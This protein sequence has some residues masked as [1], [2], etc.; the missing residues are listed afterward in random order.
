[1]HSFKNEEKVG[2]Q[3][4]RRH[5]AAGPTGLQQFFEESFHPVTDRSASPPLVTEE[6]VGR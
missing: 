3:G 1:V 4:G 6:L 2:R 5:L